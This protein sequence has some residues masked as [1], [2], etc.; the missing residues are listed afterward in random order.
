MGP[1]CRSRRPPRSRLGAAE[2]TCPRRRMS[3]RTTRCCGLLLSQPLHLVEYR[4]CNYTRVS[5]QSLSPEDAKSL[6]RRTAKPSYGVAT[7]EV[8]EVQ[9][10]YGTG[11]GT[12]K[13]SGR[14]LFARRNPVRSGSHLAC[15]TTGRIGQHSPEGIERP[16][17]GEFPS[18]FAQLITGPGGGSEH[19]IQTARVPPKTCQAR[20]DLATRLNRT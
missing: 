19:R 5:C 11:D 12:R 3:C 1:S 17:P 4:H 18:G 14:A 15:V 9:P 8:R 13:P 6:L 10:L 2:L 7:G 16:L 20:R